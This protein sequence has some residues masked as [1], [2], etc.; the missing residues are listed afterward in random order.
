MAETNTKQ[1][2]SHARSTVNRRSVLAGAGAAIAGAAVTGGASA[3]ASKVYTA[4]A[5][6]QDKK[7]IPLFTVEN[8]PKSLAFYEETLKQFQEQVDPNVDIE[9][10][11]YQDENILQFVGTAFQTGTDLGIFSSFESHIEGWAEQ[12]YLLP[13][14]SI[15]E[16]VGAD[17]FLPGTRAVVDG[18]DYV[19]PAQANA[20]ALW[21]RMDLMESEGL[22]LPTSYDELHAAVE[23]LHGKNGV[24]GISSGV[25]T[26]PN[27]TTQFFSPYLYQSGWDFFDVEGNLTFDQAPVL[28]AINRWAGIL[29]FT[30]PSM[31]NTTYPDISNLFASGRAAFAT[32]PGR[33]GV[34]VAENAPDLAE[35]ITVMPIPAGPF[36]TQQLH[37]GGGSPF[38]IYADTKYPE[39]AKQFLQFML[40]GER[41]LALAMTVPGHLLPPLQSVRKMVPDYKS[42]F[43]D[44]HGDWVITLND[45]VPQAFSPDSSMGSVNN[46]QF[47]GKM[48][49]HCPWGA[50][51]WGT[52]PVDGR[53]FQK[54]LIEGVDAEQAWTEACD[55][56][57]T[58]R[59]EYLAENP[60]WEPRAAATPA[61]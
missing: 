25:G 61:S 28:D 56:L 35:K 13:I 59:E 8:D 49:N 50:R 45:L 14:D 53:M 2:T 11:V 9:V 29:K 4:P 38:S 17:D 12:G 34:S 48:N 31:Y 16:S 23:A 44:K 6:L 27:L 24:V 3:K 42:E 19:M 54:I 46:E 40:T 32:F 15:I 7:V 30:S 18:H 5:L 10:S 39:E 36:M 52:D 58:I 20:S 26:V 33:L 1:P 22:D 41:L 21:V 37:F 47:L 60:D 57:A 43:M 55:E 51:V